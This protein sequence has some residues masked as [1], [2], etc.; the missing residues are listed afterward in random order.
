MQKI[1]FAALCA[2]TVLIYSGQEIYAQ[3][4]VPSDSLMERSNIKGPLEFKGFVKE[5]SK[6]LKGAV[7]TLYESPNGS[8]D[9]LTEILKT[10]T[11]GNGQFEFKLEVNKFYMLSVEKSGYTTKKIDFDT[12]VTKAREEF[13]NVPIFSFEVDMVQD[14][15]GLAYARSVASVFYQIKRNEFDYQLDYSKEEMEE[16]ERLIREQEEKR[17]LAD[18]AAKK[19]FEVEE[20][21]R[22]LRENENATAEQI[23][24]A[25]ITVGDGSKEKTV[26]GF[27]KVF[28][29]VDSL[30]DKKAVAMYDKLLEER[31]NATASGN[32][33]DFQAIFKVAQK[34]EDT[35]VKQAEE[36]RSKSVDVLKK[37]KEEASRKMNE[38]MAIQ[39]QGLEL[40][41]REKLAAA[42]KEEELRKATQEKE[43]QD[44][45]YYAIFDSKGD[46]N[47]AVQNLIKT[48]AK[49]DPYKEQK[50]K[51]VYAEYEKLRVTGATLSKMNFS[52]LFAAAEVAEQEA[53]QK[54]IEI[55][56]AKQQ[57]K[58]SA[59]MDQVEEKKRE[60]QNEIKQKIE[61]GLKTAS[62]DRISQLSVFKEA[63][64]KNDPYK[65]QK[66]AVM[67]DEYV[68]Q[69]QK[70]GGSGVVN[71]D[72]S[73]LFKVADA[74]EA[75][76][77]QEAKEQLTK[78]KQQAQDQ[79]EAQRE[80]IRKEKAVLAEKTATMVEESHKAKLADTKDKKEKQLADALESGGGDRDAAVAAIMK[81]LPVTGD[82]E[83]D[84]ERA[85][86][87]YDAYLQESQKIKQS[88]NAGSK[89][90]FAVLFQA[91]DKAELARL[92]R[93]YEQKQVVEK[94]RLAEYSDRRI[95]QATEIAKAQ[96]KAASKEV[97]QA[98]VAYEETLLK[99]EAQRQ[100]RLAEQKK[101]DEDLAKAKEM[102][103]VRRVALENE[104]KDAELAKMDAER[105]Q[106]LDA[107][108]KE[109]EALLAAELVTR[110]KQEEAAKKEADLKLAEIE[111]ARM[112]AEEAAR[113][114]E[115]A[116][117]KEEDK[118]KAAEEKSKRDA[119]LALAKEAEEVRK[120]E[121]QKAKDE[122]KRLAD[123]LKAKE[124]VELAAQKESERKILEENQRLAAE[125]KARKDA[126][127][128]AAKAASDR[129]ASEEKARKD[130][131]LAAA[132]VASDR[133]AA[134]EKARKDAELAAAKA[135]EAER[136]AVSDRLVA[137]EK[138]KQQSDLAA[139][140]AAEEAR[141]TAEAKELA[142]KE[143]LAAEEKARQ[144]AELATAKAAEEK[145]V[146]DDKRQAEL[147]KQKAEQDEKQRLANYESL[148]VKGDG[149][150]TTKDYQVAMRNYQDAKQLYPDNKDLVKKLSDTESQLDRIAKEETDRLAIDQKFNGL[151]EDGESAI[152]KEDYKGAIAKFEEASAL[153]P[154]D[155]APKQR[156]KDANKTLEQ[157]ALAE[158]EKQANERK[159]VLLMQEGN[160]ALKTN[161]LATAKSKYEE[162]SGMKPQ[163]SEPKSR[164]AEIADKEQELALAE[165]DKKKKEEEAKKKF[166]EQQKLEEE[167]KAKVL[168]ARIDAID[169]ATA[170][171]SNNTDE[172]RIEKYEKLKESI[173]KLDMKAEEQRRAFLSEL[174]K[175]YPEGMTK[176]QVDGKNFILLRHV[177]NSNNVVTIYEKK[178]WDWGGVF[179][180]KDS[181]IAITEAIY[182]LEIGKY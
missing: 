172:A 17:R 176:E 54:D 177:I 163:D 136:K 133:V 128:L 115:A 145:R 34:L 138:A 171:T 12:D 37:E 59:F 149:A 164:L 25:A 4:S 134:E 24:Q 162:A 8:K 75:K 131:E 153:K 174:A 23:I 22:L 110:R 77:K 47:L 182:K 135:A 21:A 80:L 1:A 68:K 123:Q 154:A 114:A 156:I 173:E 83:L 109:Q 106:R 117:I 71:I 42:A 2:F 51:A 169:Q 155:Q 26:E 84:Q 20:A 5:L 79:L 57:S 100:E 143:R 127:L 31:K 129:I 150:F 52:Q 170:T 32:K 160:T 108:K 33:I 87:V 73:T 165:L 40:V 168:Q 107:E 126:E 6:Q 62:L 92:E 132:K 46:G 7:V 111:K 118:R 13:T 69:K 50:A 159:F 11:G 27:L 158:K 181:D 142:D 28:S 72:F 89:V 55:D 147:A 175:I 101:K 81:V 179:Y 60:E 167:K 63:L 74:E 64:P 152:T 157:I 53:I 82:N 124:A 113:V 98:E 49:N 14:L 86:A 151:M 139:A 103:Q 15:D 91:A 10:V 18:L 144:A 121:A 56:N 120:L 116:R 88:G 105:Q 61:A 137:E 93:Q 85:A 95:E 58:L 16:E 99:V 148:I 141:K 76:I 70:L 94:E 140:K 39:Q 102:E 38:A 90:D 146:A 97:E 65:D 180:F 43:A 119:E 125:E 96:Q 67:Y 19:K 166:E 45:I 3:K 48:Y 161:D 178:T 66:A 104:K 112:L 36:Q 9:N 35:V 78:E 122:E 130:S 44:Q 41:A 30:R 29:E